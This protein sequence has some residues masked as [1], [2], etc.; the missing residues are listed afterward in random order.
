[1]KYAFGLKCG[2]EHR[3]NP[4]GSKNIAKS[5]GTKSNESYESKVDKG[6]VED[7]VSSE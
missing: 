5:M 2:N 6:G 3:R 4:D 1:M 7:G